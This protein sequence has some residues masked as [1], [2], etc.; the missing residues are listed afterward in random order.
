MFLKKIIFAIIFVLNANFNYSQKTTIQGYIK[1]I[2]NGESLIGARIYNLNNEK[3]VLSNNYGYYSIQ[4]KLGDSLQ[5][6][7]I[8]YQTK[9]II[10]TKNTVL[11]VNLKSSNLLN[12]VDVIVEQPAHKKNEISTLSIPVKQIKNLPTITG[13]TDILRAYQL[14]P[15]VKQGKEGTSGLYVRG[16]SP[17]QNLFILDDMP[18]YYVNHIGGFVSVFDANAINSMTLYKGG[19]PAKFG[20]RTSSVVDFRMKEGNNKKIIT[21][22]GLGVLSSKLYV[23]GPIKKDTSSFFISARRSNIDLISRTSDF[24]YYKGNAASGYTFYDINTKFTFN[25]KNKSKIQ[26]ISYIGRDRIFFNYRFKN[27]TTSTVFKSLNEIKWGNKM[28]QIKYTSTIGSKLFNTSTLGTSFFS[29]N[30]QMSTTIKQT[31]TNDIQAESSINFL[32]SVFDIILKSDF[33]YFANDKN[34]IQFGFE[35]INHIFKP[36]V[37]SSKTNGNITVGD[38]ITGSNQLISQEIKLYFQDKIKFTPRFFANIGLHYQTYFVQ[39]QTLM[40]LQPRLLFNYNLTSN[41]AIRLAYSKMNQNI[42]LLTNSGTGAP[43]DLWVPA[44]KTLKPEISNQITMAFV[45]TINNQYQYS[46]EAYYK[47]LKNLIDYKDGATF[48]FIGDDWEKVVVGNG[49]GTIKGVEFLFKK[50]QGKLQG[51]LGY[52]LSKNIRQFDEINN[53]NEFYYKNDRRHDLSIVGFYEINKHIT[54]SATWVFTTGAPITL[55]QEKYDIL[56]PGLNW[57]AQQGQDYITNNINTAQI[58]NGKN[59]YRLPNYH[60]LD[61]GI[62]L[63]KEK[64]RGLR[65]WRFGLYNAYNRQNPFFLY[66]KLVDNEVK[67]YQLSLFP[68][69]PSISYTFRFK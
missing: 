3:G 4:C 23:E 10:A 60:K 59:A 64:N 29:Y 33:E 6:S 20:G 57:N 26:F 43:T 45:Q 41:T 8:G 15:G 66:Y 68:L 18:L 24:F 2:D 50:T 42:H 56:I 5:F 54:I 53:G 25:F 48:L 39:N 28:A 61:I 7:Y 51:W 67:L 44:T 65:T 35:G 34:K 63:N 47:Q 32:S 55:A 31:S 12:T 36:G 22:V 52:T 46:I 21:E 19:F 17:D 30:T 14:M 1:D 38:S 11:N 58:Y 16:G 37:S 40:S 49:R 27:K 62:V 9:I 69:I 13:E